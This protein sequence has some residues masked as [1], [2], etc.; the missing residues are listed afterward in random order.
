MQDFFNANQQLGGRGEDDAGKRCGAMLRLRHLRQS[1]ARPEQN[2]NG[3]LFV[4]EELE[5]RD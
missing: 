1:S 3:A 5:R 4:N 2:R